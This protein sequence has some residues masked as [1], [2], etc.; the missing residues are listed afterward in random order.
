LDIIDTVKGIL[1]IDKFKKVKDVHELS[2]EEILELHM[3][4]FNKH[5]IEKPKYEHERINFLIF[6]DIIG[7]NNGA[8]RKSGSALQNLIIKNISGSV[9]FH[10]DWQLSQSAL[11]PLAYRKTSGNCSYCVALAGLAVWHFQ[12]HQWQ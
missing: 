10:L 12:S 11:L 4:K 9:Y 1:P 5:H 6:D 7:T 8:F 3:F 2:D